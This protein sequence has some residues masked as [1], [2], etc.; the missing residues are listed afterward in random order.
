MCTL[1]GKMKVSSKLRRQHTSFLCNQLLW[2]L[3]ECHTPNLVNLS[4]WLLSQ[5]SSSG[6]FLFPLPPFLSPLLSSSFPAAQKCAELAAPSLS[7]VTAAFPSHL[8][9]FLRTP[10][11]ELVVWEGAKLEGSRVKATE[12]AAITLGDQTSVMNIPNTHC[13]WWSEARKAPIV[14]LSC[15]RLSQWY[16]CSYYTIHRKFPCIRDCW[17]NN[18]LHKSAAG[19]KMHTERSQ[20]HLLVISCWLNYVKMLR[21]W[22]HWNLHCFLF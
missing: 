12:F 10:H 9:Q 16:F 11:T 17:I 2:P 19:L 1:E 18:C 14:F 21:Q 6:T 7:L 5:F 8:S 22:V 20:L 13:C 15:S 3:W 4:Y